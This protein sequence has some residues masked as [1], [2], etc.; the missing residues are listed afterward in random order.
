MKTIVVSQ[1]V[2][3]IAQ[4]SEPRDSLDQRLTGFILAAGFFPIGLSNSFFLPQSKIETQQTNLFEF[5]SRIRPHG[6]I[7]SGGNDIGQHSERDETERALLNYAESL[8]LPLLGICRGMQMMAF[9]S[10]TICHEVSGHVATNHH[11][12]GEIS[13]TVNSYHNFAL[14]E[15]PLDCNAL[16]FSEDG[17]IEA[18]SH[19]A[20]PWEGWM[21]H[22]ERQNPFDE[23]DI[24]RFQALF[25]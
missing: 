19:K 5:L 16:A 4:R 8:R 24:A 15:I 2:D 20:L 13:R 25:G 10:G 17:E 7:L 9:R 3:L 1:R 14:D 12:V 23:E 18:I 6:I 21:W 11:L 22:P